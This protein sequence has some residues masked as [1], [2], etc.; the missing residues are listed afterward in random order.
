VAIWRNLGGFPPGAPYRS[1][2]VEPMLGAVFDLAEAQ[3]SQD[4]VT[5]PDTGQVAWE[6]TITGTGPRPQGPAA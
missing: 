2:G 3:G 4:A 5:V 6:L 1:I